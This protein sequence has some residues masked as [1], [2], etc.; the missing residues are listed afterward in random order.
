MQKAFKCLWLCLK[1]V[2]DGSE[3]K[4]GNIYTDQLTLSF[5]EI[6]IIHSK[7]LFENVQKIHSSDVTKAV[8]KSSIK[9]KARDCNNRHKSRCHIAICVLVLL[10]SLA[11]HISDQLLHFESRSM[12]WKPTAYT[13]AH[14]TPK[15]Q[16]HFKYKTSVLWVFF[17]VHIKQERVTGNKSLAKFNLKSEASS[18]AAAASRFLHQT[19]VHST[20]LERCDN[21][22]SPFGFSWGTHTS[23]LTA[24]IQY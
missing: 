11:H 14:F 16:S 10:C 22:M 24:E 20:L 6:Q 1:N 19:N 4:A 2:V 13:V 8:L 18:E 17:C 3:T 7:Y 21:E 12:I 23:V 5:R 15:L 9:Q